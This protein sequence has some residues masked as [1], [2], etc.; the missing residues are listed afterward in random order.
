M[1]VNEHVLKISGKA[2]ILSGLTIGKNYDI[3]VGDLEC[4]KC[5]EIPTDSGKVDKTYTLRLSNLSEVNIISE[6]EVIKSTQKTRSQSQVLRW[7]IEKRWQ[8]SGSELEKEDFYIKEMSRVI[9]NYKDENT[10]Y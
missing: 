10:Y 2:N 1:E 7:E 9:R 4:R 5:E 8:E 3:T 6:K